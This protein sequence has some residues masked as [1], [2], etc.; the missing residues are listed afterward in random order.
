MWA[1]G[2][3]QKSY[4]SFLFKLKAA[5]YLAAGIDQQTQLQRQISLLR[6]SNDLLWRLVVIKN[7]EVLRPQVTHELAMLIHG[8]EENVNFIDSFL[9]GDNRRWIVC[10]DQRTRRGC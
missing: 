4:C 2:M 9:N 1:N 5:V 8:D 3:L 7:V 10:F 6:E